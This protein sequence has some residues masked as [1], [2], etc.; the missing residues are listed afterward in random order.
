ML[1]T[2]YVVYAMGVLCSLVIFGMFALVVLGIRS[3]RGIIRYA[4]IGKF[5]LMD[6]SWNVYNLDDGNHPVGLTL[7]TIFYAGIVCIAALA[8]VVTILPCVIAIIGKIERYKF[9]K[10]EEANAVMKRLARTAQ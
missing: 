6:Q 4:R 8:W 9:L 5:D 7:D 10:A 2:L 3:Y 1:E